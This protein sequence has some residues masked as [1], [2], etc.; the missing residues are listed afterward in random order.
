MHCMNYFKKKGLK[1]RLGITQWHLDRMEM[2]AESKPYLAMMLPQAAPLTHADGTAI[3]IKYI[4]PQPVEYFQ[5]KQEL[6]MKVHMPN[7]RFNPNLSYGILDGK[8]THITYRMPDQAP[9]DE[10]SVATDVQ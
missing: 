9:N 1:K 2:A 4:D 8:F 5:R 3:Q 7:E 6:K 10:R